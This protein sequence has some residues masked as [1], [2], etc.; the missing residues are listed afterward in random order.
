MDRATGDYIGMLAT[1]M[2]GIALGEALTRNH[3]KNR[4]M[5]SVEMP[6][7]TELF[8]MKKAIHALSH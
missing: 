5:S 2:N 1:V 6:K 7:I 8:V 4:V 3:Q